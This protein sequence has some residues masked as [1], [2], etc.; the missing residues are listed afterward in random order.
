MALA[1]LRYTGKFEVIVIVDGS[2]DGTA[3]KL[4]ELSC[5]F[6]L[7]IIEQPNR[8]QAAARNGGAEEAAGEIIL[9]LD[10][11]MIAEPQLLAEHARMHRA[12]ADAVTGEVPVHSASPAGLVTDALAKAA[13]W[14]RKPPASPFHVYSGNLSVAKRVFREI[15]G[16]D[17]ELC[18]GG[19]GGE[20]LDFG[21]RLVGRYDVRHNRAAMAWQRSAV[22]PREFMRRAREIALSDVRVI[23]K[24]PHVT[25]ELLANRGAPNAGRR[26]LS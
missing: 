24:H 15:G 4:K 8:G 16:F 1:E 26:P 18:R 10:D 20:D 22:G 7:R 25:K 14:Q 5:P 9:F 13:A 11:D 23:G 12:G 6:P 2:T 17:E 3:A 19:Y 21:L